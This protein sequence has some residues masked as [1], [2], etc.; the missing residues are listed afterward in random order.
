MKIFLSAVAACIVLVSSIPLGLAQEGNGE[1][2]VLFDGSSLDHW[3]Q[4]PGSTWHI[5]DGAVV[6]SEGAATQL[7]SRGTFDDFELNLEFWVDETVN[8][9]VFIRC[10]D[11]EAIG[12]TSCYEVNI[13]DDRPDP[14]YRSGA[15]VG[16]AEPMEHVDTIDR[17]NTYQIR[18]QGGHLQIRLNG[19]LTVD[20]EDDTFSGGHIT[21]QYGG[22]GTV[23][24]RNITLRPL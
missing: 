18:A 10:G 13:W 22:M 1:E 16:F 3:L 4:A 20:T 12:S 11:L 17:W 21:L 5:D 6:S 8:S 7:V 24:F 15:V 23:K 14:A 19:I 2:I 9:G